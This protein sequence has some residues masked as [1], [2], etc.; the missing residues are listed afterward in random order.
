MKSLFLA[1]LVLISFTTNSFA[2]E[3]VGGFVKAQTGQEKALGKSGEIYFLFHLSDGRSVAYPVSFKNPKT[4]KEVL[5]NLNQ[6]YLIDANA[7]NKEI[8]VGEMK[9]KVKVLEVL[10][11]KKLSLA[12][13]SPQEN[14]R[15]KPDL[16]QR[17]SAKKKTKYRPGLS[18]INDKVTNAAILGAGA[19]LIAS[20]LMG[21]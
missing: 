12:D 11:V 5:K 7:L 19:A 1:F 14:D 10:K 8:L 9:N 6:Q 2:L 20:I 18:G 4:K 15:E 16:H 13:L 3:L 21:N 17:L